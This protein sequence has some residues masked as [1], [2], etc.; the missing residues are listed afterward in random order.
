MADRNFSALSTTSLA[1]FSNYQATSG[2]TGSVSVTITS[3]YGSDG[4]VHR[5]IVVPVIIKVQVPAYTAYDVSYTKT[6][7]MSAGAHGKCT[8]FYNNWQD[9]SSGTY[10]VSLPLNILSYQNSASGTDWSGRSESAEFSNANGDGVLFYN[11]TG[12]QKALSLY[13][14]YLAKIGDGCTGGCTCTFSFSISPSVNKVVAIGTTKTTDTNPETYDKTEKTFNFTYDEPT[15]TAYGN[16]INY[17]TAYKNIET[18]VEALDYDDK[19]IEETTYSLSTEDG[20]L[21]AT[22]AG[23]YKVKFN[24]KAEAKASGIEWTTGDTDEKIITFEIKRKAISV[25][26]ILNSTQTYKADEYEFY[27]DEKFDADIMTVN[28]TTSTSNVTGASI[29]WDETNKSIKATEAATY[30]VKFKLTDKNYIWKVGTVETTNEQNGTIKITPK[31]LKVPTISGDKVYN[32]SAQTFQLFDFDSGKDIKVTKAEGANGKTI[33]GVGGATW[34][35]KTE[36]FEAKDADTYTITLQPRSTTNYAWDDTTGGTGVRTCEFDITKKEVSFTFTCSETNSSWEYG[37]SGVTVTATE[38]SLST[39]SLSLVFFYDNKSNLLTGT[40]DLVNGKVTEIEIPDSIANGKHT[41]YAELN[42]STGANGNYKLAENKNSFKFNVTSGSI[43]LSKIEWNYTVDGATGGK[44][45]DGDELPFK[46]KTG[47]TTVGV[48]YE[49]SAIIPDD[50][51]FIVIDTS[52]YTNGYN[53]DI[54]KNTVTADGSTYTL[55]VALKSTDNTKEFTDDNGDKSSTCDLTIT[56]KIVK[57][58]FDLSGVKWEYYYTDSNGTKQTKDYTGAIEYDDINYAV[59]IKASTLPAGLTLVADYQFSDRQRNVDSY[60]VT[61]SKSNF[62]W[63]QNFNEPDM[64]ASTLTLSWQIKQKNLYTNFKYERVQAAKSDGT[65]V[66]FYN[67]VLDIA[68]KYKN[69]VKYEYTDSDGT[70]VSLQE[71][72][73]ALDMTSPKKYT[74]RAYI[75][76]AATAAANFEVVDNGSDPTDT[77]TTGSNNDPVYA[78]IDGV[79]IDGIKASDYKVVYDGQQ[80]FD[81]LEIVSG[82]GVK[83]SDFTVTYY[84]GATLTAEKFTEGEYPVNAGEYMMEVKLGSSAQDD[85]ILLLDVIRI[86][87]EK[88]EIALPTVG[89]ILFSGEYVNLADYLGGSYAEYKDIINLSGDYL[90]IRNVSQNGY[91]A[92][93]TLTNSNYKWATQTTA[94]TASKKLFAVKLYDNAPEVLDDAT[95]ELKWNIAPLVVDVS[96]MWNKSGKEGATLN[97]P[98]NITKL[99]NAETLSVLYKYYD[100]ADQYIE[101]PELKGGKSFRV[102]AVF[103]GIDAESGNVLFK[104]ADGNFGTVS[105]KISYTV[106]QS[107]AAAFLGSTLSFLKANWLWLVIAAVAL[108][109]LILIIALAARSAKKKRIREEQR[110]L[111]EKEEKKREQEERERKEEERRQREDERRR[112]EREE[113]M[114]ARMA[115][116]QMMPQMPQMMGGQMPQSMPQQAQSMSAGG[117]SSNEIAEL[118]AEMAAM[119]A[120]QDMAKEIAELRMEV[121][122]A[123]QNAVMRSDVNALRFGGEQAVGGVTL[124]ALTEIIR[125]EV[126]NALANEKAAA[127][128]APVAPESSAATQVPPD[129]VMTTVT[130]T[131]IDTTKKPA[132]PAQ[133]APSG[134][135]VVRNFVAPMPVDDGRVFDVGGFYT[136]ADPIT[137]MGFTDDENK[138]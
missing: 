51:D 89:G 73:D 125:T 48:Q 134:R 138:D 114:A 101:T 79:M 25:P 34:T 63:N 117:A 47:S 24:L 74:V 81:K 116:P 55:T 41:L 42:G 26:T 7:S 60:S 16:T 137:D 132:Q 3:L 124:Q 80:H 36:K 133:A 33:T 56:W 119:K 66:S 92:R 95:A 54:F 43:D 18:T 64:S 76:P 11:D 108:I 52:K 6:L 20:T 94:E 22:E 128:S 71:I 65:V 105:D 78:V 67:K 21:T 37:T 100:D 104:T 107:A 31:K 130:T 27:P 62:S 86:T 126:K 77:I 10:D 123:E 75:D 70:V 135:T 35:D 57:G 39:D 38:N 4:I 53:G 59:K 17:T 91:K 23:K 13:S 1:G 30:T 49:L 45:E 19:A 68:E 120:T 110:R 15:Y 82:N 28:E 61:A 5:F 98:E 50:M 2:S 44:I 85:Y 103:G 106:P 97:L 127:Q 102:E 99:I 72:I 69:F 121:M 32:G 14:F 112:E 111:E 87:I 115:Q 129:A 93:L 84:K 96:E 113:R 46:L 109:L 12:A 131:K 29:T 9:A 8:M 136:P 58:T 40:P 90:D 83:I 118:K 122:R 88:K